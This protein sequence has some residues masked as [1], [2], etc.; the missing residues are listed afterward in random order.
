MNFFYI[1]LK[2]YAHTKT[3]L[4]QNLRR[5]WRL[6]VFGPIRMSIWK[7]IFLIQK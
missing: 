3:K 6:D 1:I 4:N 2:L 5:Y 7:N